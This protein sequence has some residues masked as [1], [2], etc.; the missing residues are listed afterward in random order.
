MPM[1]EGQLALMII[2]V[3]EGMFNI[4]EAVVHEPEAFLSRVSG[5]VADG[6]SSGVPVIYIQHLGA[7][8]HPLEPGTEGSR[9]HHAIA[10]IAGE[11]VIQ[12][13]ESDAFLGTSLQAD[14]E[15]LGVTGL[16]V[17]GMQTEYC[18]DTTC[19]RAHGLGYKVFLAQDAHTTVA[20]ESLTAAQIIAHHNE[21]LGSAYVTLC[22]AEEA[23]A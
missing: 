2:D 9:I 22:H 4:P 7:P 5:L 1:T 23:F 13:R 14:L 18:V 8:G 6:R 15:E 10:P 12:K 3:Q 17:C 19:R 20:A 11:R 21:T 16:V